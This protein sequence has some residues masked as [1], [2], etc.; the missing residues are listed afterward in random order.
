MRARLTLI[1]HAAL[2]GL[3][4]VASG[5]A[6]AP[7]SRV[8]DARPTGGYLPGGQVLSQGGGQLIG[9]AKRPGAQAWRLRLSLD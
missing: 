9:K 1:P 5:C 6:P 2:A 3:V 4:A 8:P 7:V